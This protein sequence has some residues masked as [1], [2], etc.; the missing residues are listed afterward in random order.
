MCLIE[1]LS[2]TI[3]G[4]RGQNMKYCGGTNNGDFALEAHMHGVKTVTI[5]VTVESPC[6]KDLE[7]LKT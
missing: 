3:A 5:H 6:E 4:G 1:Q 7:N 2:V